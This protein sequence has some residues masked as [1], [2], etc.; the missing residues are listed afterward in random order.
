MTPSHTLQVVVDALEAAQVPHMLAGSFASSLHG[1]ARTTA[2]IDIV[3]DPSAAS[4]ARLL[5]HLDLDR[6]YVDAEA[7]RRALADRDPFNI[8]DVTNGWKVNLIIRK[9]RPFSVAEFER[10]T[11]TTIIGVPAFVATAE[12]TVLA[13]LEWSRLGGSDRQRRDVVEILRIQGPALD[14]EHLDTWAEALGLTELLS[15]AR[16]DAHRADDHSG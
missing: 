13:K 1:M 16:L 9:E 15:A 11:P 12:D 8:V 2:D 4:L 7:A 10:R 3:I 6:F 5:D 14:H